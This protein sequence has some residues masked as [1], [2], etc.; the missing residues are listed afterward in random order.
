VPFIDDTGLGA[1]V[2]LRNRLA[3]KGQPLALQG[4]IPLVRRTFGL[5]GLRTLL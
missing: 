5:G 2:A 1:V 4:L 3:A